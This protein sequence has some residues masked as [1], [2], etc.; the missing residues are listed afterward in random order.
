MRFQRNGQL[1]QGVK[2]T[3]PLITLLERIGGLDRT[4][5]VGL[6]VDERLGYLGSRRF[7]SAEQA[8]RWLKPAEE[9]FGAFHAESW[10]IKAFAKELF[11]EDLQAC[12]HFVPEAIAQRYPALLR[13]APVRRPGP[14]A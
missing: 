4:L 6:T 8:L 3:S 9:V 2:P 14:R 5:I 11:L 10:R 7:D 1:P 13:P 12:C